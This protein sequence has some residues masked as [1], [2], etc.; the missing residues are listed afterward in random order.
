MAAEIAQWYNSVPILTRTLI[1]AT[2]ATTGCYLVGLVNPYL[3]LLHW[4]EL[5]KAQVTFASGGG[6]Q[7]S[8]G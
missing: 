7:L 4:P 2:V 8:L 6:G 5:R 1:T 3:L